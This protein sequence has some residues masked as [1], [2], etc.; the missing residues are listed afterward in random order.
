[1]KSGRIR[2]EWGFSRGNTG[3]AA[4]RVM[5]GGNEIGGCKTKVGRWI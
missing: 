2:S 5:E 1:M 4:C 3:M